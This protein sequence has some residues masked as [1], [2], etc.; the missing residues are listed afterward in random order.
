MMPR[1]YTIF[2]IEMLKKG[3]SIEEIYEIINEIDILIRNGKCIKEIFN[4]YDLKT[5]LID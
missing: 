3:Y 1:K 4:R 2:I 5:E